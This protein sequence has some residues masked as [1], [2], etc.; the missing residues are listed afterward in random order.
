MNGFG[1][2]G[3]GREKLAE[4]GVV[5]RG[6]GG[7]GKSSFFDLVCA[8]RV[9]RAGGSGSGGST[10]TAGVGAGVGAGV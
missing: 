9:L 6:F 1:G 2:F 5:L 4:I 8:L 10:G 3:W 7:G